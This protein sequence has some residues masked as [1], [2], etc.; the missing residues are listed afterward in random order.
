MIKYL[1][2]ILIVIFSFVPLYA[3]S[4]TQNCLSFYAVVRCKDQIEGQLPPQHSQ[5]SVRINK[6][7]TVIFVDY[8][9]YLEQIYPEGYQYNALIVDL[10]NNEHYNYRFIDGDKFITNWETIIVPS[11]ASIYIIDECTRLFLPTV[12]FK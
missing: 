11:G 5:L 6:I 7:N 12:Q 1:I 8:H 2:L 4:C 9:L 10:P 3:D